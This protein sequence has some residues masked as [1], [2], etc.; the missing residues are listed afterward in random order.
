MDLADV[1]G[2]VRTALE[3][4]CNCTETAL[5]VYRHGIDERIVYHRL[6][7]ITDGSGAVSPAWNDTETALAI[8]CHIIKE[9]NDCRFIY[10]PLMDMADGYGAVSPAL[11]LH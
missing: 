7:D 1:Y 9:C 3:L 11:K 6:M 2:A 4:H 5:T 10:H 8:H